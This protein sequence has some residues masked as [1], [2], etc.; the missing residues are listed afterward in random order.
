MNSSLKS[1]TCDSAPEPLLV[2]EAGV[3]Y[4]PLPRPDPFVAWVELMEVVEALCPR[5]PPRAPFLGKAGF[6]L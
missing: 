4:A 2:R 1:R 5:W 3:V 6:A